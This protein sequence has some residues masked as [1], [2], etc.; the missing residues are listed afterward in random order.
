[1][2]PHSGDYGAIPILRMLGDEAGDDSGEDIARAAFGERGRA[3][4]IDP[5]FAI[6]KSDDGAVTF[7]D[8]GRATFGSEVLGEGEAVGLT[9]LADLPTRR[10]ISPG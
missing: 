7:E 2:Q 4:G 8:D 3:G 10:P 5:S 1:M 6:G 9:S